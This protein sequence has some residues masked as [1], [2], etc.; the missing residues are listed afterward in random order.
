MR[1]KVLK[2]VIRAAMDTFGVITEKKVP[3]LTFGH[4]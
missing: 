1:Q 2:D 4:F 3:F